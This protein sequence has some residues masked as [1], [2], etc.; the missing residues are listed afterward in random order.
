MA[1]D[2]KHPGGRPRS[3]WRLAAWSIAAALILLPLV[4][5]RFT[6]EVDWTPADFACASALVLG[7]GLT[8]EL[9]VRTTVNRAYRAAVAV[10]L[11]AA[12]ILIWINGA[13]G[14]I[15]S[16]DHPANR[17]YGGVLAVGII[18]AVIVRFRAYGMAR[19]LVAVALAQL[20]VAVIALVAGLG[21]TGPI[22]VF[23]A[24]LWLA[25]AWLF[26]KAAKEQRP[27]GETL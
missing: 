15:G 10:G 16:E 2:A 7:V 27:T 12:F 24:G 18:G 17:M 23:F 22:T 5:M 8:Y 9:T 1:D 6:D 25:S 14:I 19:V 26:E 4:G 11:T 3:R 21:F 20:L 13:V